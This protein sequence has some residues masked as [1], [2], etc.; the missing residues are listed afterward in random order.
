MTITLGLA[1]EDGSFTI[2]KFPFLYEIRFLP[3]DKVDLPLQMF[4]CN[5]EEAKQYYDNK[6]LNFTLIDDEEFDA[7]SVFILEYDAKIPVLEKIDGELKWN[8]SLNSLRYFMY[9]LM[10]D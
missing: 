6:D 5:S 2:K 3:I 8:I 4:A 1:H 10:R 7:D 9:E